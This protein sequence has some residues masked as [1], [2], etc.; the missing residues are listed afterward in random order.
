MREEEKGGG[1]RGECD[2][3]D[4]KQELIG[5]LWLSGPRLVSCWRPGADVGSLNTHMLQ[6][7]SKRSKEASG[8][9][10]ETSGTRCCFL[11]C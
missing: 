8:G 5:W 10:D 1:G 3:K 4:S 2:L 11:A 7:H 6:S 9:Q